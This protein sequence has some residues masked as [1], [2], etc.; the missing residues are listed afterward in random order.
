[1]TNNPEKIGSLR[2]LGIEV[3]RR[4]P[5]LIPSNPFSASYLEVKRRRMQHELPHANGTAEPPESARVTTGLTG[6]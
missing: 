5:V 4:V 6:S 2:R 3:D 1:M